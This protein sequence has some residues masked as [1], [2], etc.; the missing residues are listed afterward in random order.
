[1]IKA[2]STNQDIKAVTTT[3]KAAEAS[4][5]AAS[6]M[7]SIQQAISRANGSIGGVSAARSEA[8]PLEQREIHNSKETL[9]KEEKADPA[10]GN[11]RPEDAAETEKSGK[12]EPVKN[13]DNKTENEEP[14][15]DAE[16]AA[17][18]AQAQDAQKAAI[19]NVS[20]QTEETTTQASVQSQTVAQ[21]TEEAAPENTANAGKAETVQITKEQIDF[22]DKT[23][24]EIE[25][26]VAS[27]EAERNEPVLKGNTASEM[28]P[29]TEDGAAQDSGGS[30]VYNIDN[31]QKNGKTENASNTQHNTA[32]NTAVNA[33]GAEPDAVVNLP[34]DAQQARQVV[35]DSVLSQV[36]SAVSE[37]KSELYIKF[38]PD[39]F[40]GMQIRL[41][42]T[43]EGL[44]AQIRTNDPAMRGMIN[45]ELAQLTE[46]LRAR[47]INVVEM[48]VYHEQQTANNQFMDQHGS[49]RWSGEQS[50]NGGGHRYPVETF[51][52]GGYE[53][54]YARMI[55]TEDETGAGGVIYSA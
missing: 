17:Q 27:N 28:N 34:S 38:K 51:D 45:S 44:R 49:G 30:R 37:E 6:F 20:A 48:D 23:L 41:T 1:M 42:M 47:G 4:S 35:F 40:G 25:T 10:T 26:A 43:E 55:P 5:Q 7:E 2:I 15:D 8:Q 21:L 50:Q 54:A 36:E 24:N 3:A 19:Q 12:D 14:T 52:E 11:E 39:V 18:A 22:I 31:I 29:E 16:A 9:R 33:A 53:A 13:E 46:T 32:A